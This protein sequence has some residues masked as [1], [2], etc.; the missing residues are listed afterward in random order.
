MVFDKAQKK[1][2]FKIVRLFESIRLGPIDVKNRIVMPAMGLGY[3][4]DYTF[5]DR[6]KA[7]FKERAEGGVGLMI[8]GPIAVDKVGAAP[9]V[10]EL[11]DDRNVEALSRFIEEIKRETGVKAGTQLF[12]M[13]RNAFS[14]FTGNMPIAPSAIPGKLT[15]ETPREMTA[16]DIV[17]VQNAF[18]DAAK[19]AKEAGFDYVEPVGCTGYLISQFLSPLTNK[20]K[21]QYGGP[22]ENRMR[23]GIE[24]VKGIKDAIGDSLA[25]GIRIA[26]N[27]FMEGGHTN[28]ES[29]LFAA[30]C[31]KA[32]ADAINV[33]GGWHETYIPQLTT[34][35]PQGMY[36]YL[37]RGI[38]EKVNIPV[39]ASNRL[40]NPEVAE[41]AIR[42]N[43]CDLVC[44]G[45]PL[46]CDPELP[47]KVKEGRFDEI[48]PC[49]AC[50]QG[51]FNAVFEGRSVSCILNPRAGRE[52][53]FPKREGVKENKK[54]KIVIAGG[55]PAGMEFAH[56]AASMGHDVAIYEKET[57]LGGQINLAKSPPGKGEF[58]NI[59]ESLENRM[60]KEGV[61]IRLGMELTPEIVKKT[62]PDILVVA[63]GAVPI[64]IK[65][66][67][68]D[69]PHVV[70]AWDVLMERVTH[71][72]D[73][74]VIIGGS[75]TGCETAHYIA[76]METPDA[77]MFKFILYHD[78]EEIEFM[79]ELL[80]KTGRTITVIDMVE[81]LAD[82]VGKTSRWSLMKSLKLLGVNLKP[83]TKLVEI[84]DDAVV[85]ESDEGQY[86]IPADMVI[87]AVGAKPVRGLFD[88]VSG[89]GMKIITIGDAKEPRKIT[90]AVMEGFEEAYNL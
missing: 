67:G 37:A 19:R 76:A 66:Q 31:E 34:N 36:L 1:G 28:R 68:I 42:S 4:D 90:E 55:G 80:Y 75:A 33:T 50:N 62:K 59:I 2:D 88:N 44:W 85:V 77:D 12:H 60:K 52:L 23:F 56:T 7:Y 21:D 58:L 13:G 69:K 45:R 82:N 40:G 73:N 84:K 14:Y 48:V 83:K 78:A 38:K 3:T 41:R 20:R 89:N 64:E 8:I 72:G 10:P 54:L 47:N 15:G 46:I 70:S 9:Y 26:G 29:G 25:V 27:D 16:D 74:I 5:N 63:T 53:E 65:V 6:F 81:R 30:E 11:F 51:C 18:I 71:I 43:A 79:R 39:F 87:T 86:S 32:G 57:R 17:E 35:V 24:I 49:I 22:I 61:D